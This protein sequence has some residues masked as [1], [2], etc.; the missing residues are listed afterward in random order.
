MKHLGICGP[1][2]KWASSFLN[3]RLQHVVVEGCISGANKVLSGVPQGTVLG[4][5][6]FL[7]YINDITENLSP[8]TSIRLF[9][10]DSLLY[11]IIKCKQDTEILQQ[12]LDTLQRWESRNKMVFHPGKCQ[13]IRVTNKVKPLSAEYKIHGVTLQF[14]N[15][16]KYLGV[17][18]DAKLGWKEQC[19]N[20]CRKAHLMLSFLERNFSR[21][22]PRVKE[23]CYFTL[24][25]PL[26]E[27][28]CTA[29]DPYR[30]GQIDQLERVNKRAARFVTGNRLREHG[31]TQKNMD[32]LGWPPLIER[33]SRNKVSML[34]KIRTDQICIPSEDLKF[35]AR[36]QD[37]YSIPYS[38]VDA[39]KHSF[40][41]ST[42]RLWNSLPSKS[43][44][45]PSLTSFKASLEN[46][47]F[48]HSLSN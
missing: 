42:I 2:L 4:P 38:S 1:L 34:Y 12:D 24:V 45:S 33:R 15:A 19:D 3:D 46:I 11:R 13:V 28:G 23:Q 32:N 40:F 14:F 48:H 17:T 31:N 39:H 20:V 6:F 37:S 29:W 22:P 10:D 9:A 30:S 27:Y 7:I 8:G 47:T 5:L 25:R 43:K 35:N 44:S 16:V 41:P 21:C 18:I 36:R 26:L